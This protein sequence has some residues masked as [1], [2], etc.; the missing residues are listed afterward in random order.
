MADTPQNT[1]QGS[2]K[3]L[4]ISP[5]TSTSHA[6]TMLF[7]LHLG[8]L[9]KYINAS[10]NSYR[11]SNRRQSYITVIDLFFKQNPRVFKLYKQSI[12]FTPGNYTALIQ[13]IV[14]DV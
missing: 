3:K 11:T 10:I 8:R 9:K 14:K 7:K 12:F 1:S 6:A 5:I 4:L 13:K 2:G